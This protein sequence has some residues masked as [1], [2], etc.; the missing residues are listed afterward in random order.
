MTDVSPKPPP[1][2][3][4]RWLIGIV[5]AVVVLVGGYVFYRWAVRRGVEKRYA[6]IHAAGQPVT[7]KELDEWYPTP[8]VGLNGADVYQQAFFKY[9]N[10]TMD[11]ENLPI[12]G[13]ARLPELGEPIAPE[14]L[15]AIREYLAA[16]A[17]ALELLHEASRYEQC[18]YP[19]NTSG[20]LGTLLPHLAQCRQAARLLYLQTILKSEDG[21]AEGAAQAVMD[22]LAVGRSLN[23]EPIL[24]SRLVQIAC[25]Y[26]TYGSFERVLSRT[27][28]TDG[29]LLELSEAF[30]NAKTPESIARA[31]AGERCMGIGVFELEDPSVRSGGGGQGIPPLTVLKVTGLLDMDA[32]EY[33]DIMNGCIAASQAPPG[34]LGEYAAEFD[35]RIPKLPRWC[36]FSRMLLPALSAALNKDIRDAAQLRCAATAAAVERYRLAHGD[37]PSQLADVAPEFIPEIPADPFTGTPLLYKLAE[38]SCVVYSVGQDGKDDGGVEFESDADGQRSGEQLDLPFRLWRRT[39]EPHPAEI[40]VP[41][42]EH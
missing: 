36:F 39:M 3:T 30:G 13:R 7:L 14:M 12:V 26:I 22:S 5:I 33:V 10:T 31:L 9:S 25:N 16:N 32:K 42:T 23:N 27:E 15:A 35:K 19:I 24:I 2:K 8:P 6:A 40:S 11:R 4:L 34:N 21:D 38:D 41:E 28:L 29:Q 20:G 37:L 18:R 1:D 17:E